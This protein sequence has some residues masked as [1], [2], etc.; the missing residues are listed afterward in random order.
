MRLFGIE[1]RED[2]GPQTEAE[3]PQSAR[4]ARSG[5][6]PSQSSNGGDSQSFG[7]MKLVIKNTFIGGYEENA[8]DDPP[9]TLARSASD[10]KLDCTSSASSVLF[11][12]PQR[13]GGSMSRSNSSVMSRSDAEDLDDSEL[14]EHGPAGPYHMVY[15]RSR[16][17]EG[18]GRQTGA[19]AAQDSYPQLP[20]YT[21]DQRPL[22]LLKMPNQMPSPEGMAAVQHDALPPMEHQL[23]QRPPGN[24]FGATSI[25]RPPGMFDGS[26]LQADQPSHFQNGVNVRQANFASSDLKIPASGFSEEPGQEGSGLLDMQLLKMQAELAEITAQRASSVQKQPQE[27]LAQLQMQQ[28]QLQLQMPPMSSTSDA[29]FPMPSFQ[30]PK[31]EFIAQVDS[32]PASDLHQMQQGL[33]GSASS[34]NMVQHQLQQQ[35]LESQMQQL[36]LQQQMQQ[37]QLQTQRLQQQLAG[38]QTPSVQPSDE[39]ALL[40]QIPFNDEGERASLG[41]RLHPDN[42][43]PC[44]FWFKDKTFCNKG[45]MCDFC[46]FRHPGQKNKRIRPSKNTRLQMRAAQAARAAADIPVP[47]LA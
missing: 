3:A 46:H 19:R 21:G 8:D 13:G 10:S 33:P 43:N 5:E 4:S 27:Q 35:L 2:A 30:T 6:S 44:I 28:Q 45:I 12:Y 36:Q 17:A 14:I 47:N 11:W 42:C 34:G 23:P 32:A 25:P 15:G 38:Q 18:S 24:F 40:S 39:D 29:P 31:S 7:Q 37:L 20:R 41:S 26:P 22:D 16:A 9:R 1:K